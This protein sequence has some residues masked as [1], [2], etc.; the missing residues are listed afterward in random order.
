MS[1]V[2]RVEVLSIGSRRHWTLD[3]KRRII[4][5]SFDGP[6]RV[7][8]TAR[9]HGLSAS[10]LFTWRRLA[11]QGRLVAADELP[12]FAAAVVEDDGHAGARLPNLS[13]SA[14]PPSTRVA[15][16]VGTLGRIEIVLVCGR[17]VIVDA[18]I[19]SAV[20]ARV[21]AAVEPA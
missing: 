4:A 2:A 15:C 11:R 13:P 18:D 3:E 5:E 1:K 8:E 21:I 14:D 7:S 6:R 20:L 9:R 16:S 17:R 12:G 19:E 10:Q